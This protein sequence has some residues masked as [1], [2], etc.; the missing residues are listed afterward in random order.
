M[1][2]IYIKFIPALEALDNG[3]I[4]SV[5]KDGKKFKRETTTDI[6]VKSLEL[7]L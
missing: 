2:K 1:K 3:R 5:Q 6:I 7:N 4:D